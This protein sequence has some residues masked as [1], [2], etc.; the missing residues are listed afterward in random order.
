MRL[1]VC[2]WCEYVQLV[3]DGC[4]APVNWIVV[5]SDER[6]SRDVVTVNSTPAPETIDEES[7]MFCD[8]DCLHQYSG[9]DIESWLDDTE[10]ES[11][12]SDE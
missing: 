2:E 9:E 8:I 10:P 1:L 11:R 3:P 12:A 4:L 5:S 6:G 7:L